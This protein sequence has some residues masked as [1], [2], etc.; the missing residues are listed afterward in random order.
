MCCI[1]LKKKKEH[2][3][4][5]ESIQMITYKNLDL[6]RQKLKMNGNSLK[7]QKK[8]D[9]EGLY[10][11]PST[12]L[13]LQVTMVARQKTISVLIVVVAIHLQS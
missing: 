7:R 6:E 8:M 9:L 2:K 13:S 1:S 11:L 10:R 5:L 4:M 12:A 3:K